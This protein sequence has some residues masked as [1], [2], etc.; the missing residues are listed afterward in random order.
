MCGVRICWSFDLCM[1]KIS[2]DTRHATARGTVLRAT[3]FSLIIVVE[4][5]LLQIVHSVENTAIVE[6][7]T[8]WN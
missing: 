7:E 4:P 2:Q 8:R 5:N 3:P 6:L 1:G